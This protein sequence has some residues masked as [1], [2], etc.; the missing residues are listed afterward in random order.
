[1]IDTTTLWM[2]ADL[3]LRLDAC[4]QRRRP[5]VFGNRYAI[6]TATTALLLLN[7]KRLERQPETND[8]RHTSPSGRF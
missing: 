1:M 4:Q 6:P 8:D 2:L 7:L 5:Q 3:A